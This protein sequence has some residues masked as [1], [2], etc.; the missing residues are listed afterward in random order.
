M[1][2]THRH[3]NY[4]LAFAHRPVLI[5]CPTR[6]TSPLT[7]S[8]SPVAAVDLQTMKKMTISQMAAAMG[9]RSKGTPKTLTLKERI[10]R[11]KSLT[12]A[13]KRRWL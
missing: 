4:N 1:I 13:R 7:A 12:V 3:D 6:N 5:H 11:A 2:H 10:R 9:R 8:R